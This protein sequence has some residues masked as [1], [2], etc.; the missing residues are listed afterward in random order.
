[1]DPERWRRIERLY[2]LALEQEPAQ[3]NRFLAEACE[4]DAELLGEVESLLA[5]SGATD[6]LIDRTAWGAVADQPETP[7]GLTPGARLGP[8][9]ILGPL[10]EGGMGK[11]YRGLDTRLGRAVAIKVSAEQFSKRFEREARAISA[12]NHP[13]ICTLYDVGPNY[14][15]TELIQGETL[16]DYLKEPPSTERT[17][18]IAR[19]VLEALR[20]AHRAGIIHRDLKPANIMVRSDGYVK[21]LDFGL[22]KRIPVSGAL[23][24]DSTVT[25]GPSVP[26]QILG[27]VAYMSPE[28]ILGQE[29]DQRSDL[30]AFGIVLCEMVTGQHPW[31]RKSQVDTLHAI[32][33]D[34]PPPIKAPLAG[35]ALAGIV[36][37]LLHK[38]REERYSSAEAVL[39]ALASPSPPQAPPPRA[40]TR[41]IVL[42]FRLLRRHEASDFLS[43]SLPDAITSSLA[44]ID[45]L[46]VRS[47]MAASRF[48]ALPELDMNEIAEQAQVDAILTGTIL[49]D[50]EHLRVTAQLV[51]APSG[52]VLWSNTSQVSLRDIFQL[53]DELV[54]RIV[55]SLTLPLTAREQRALKHDVPA[56]AMGYEF[57][58]RGN[59]LVATGYN[60]ENENM[61]LAR[62]LYLQSVEAD[63]KYAP[64]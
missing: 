30:F 49:S 52:T 35:V 12:L 9:Q 25:L 20:A 41:L 55:Q 43:L 26:G 59:Q 62:D 64:A 24:T 45:S 33:H 47:T 1:M 36:H 46:V 32:L 61:M 2:H 21:V 54:D 14:M 6:T 37:K 17:L 56:S 31:L 34:D 58:L 16:R 8:Y 39:E 10:G 51:E 48:A 19:Q 23:Q 53:Q 4:G 15:V 5:Q 13:H 28:Q 60:L 57:Y 27:T 38:N 63:P 50:G 18:E 40:L 11:V 3:R 7:T 22:A 29:I 44:A 42:P